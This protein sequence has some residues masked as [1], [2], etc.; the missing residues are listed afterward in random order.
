VLGSWK[1]V[2]KHVL[3]FVEL[4]RMN[5]AAASG[6][7]EDLVHW[8]LRYEK[9]LLYVINGA[10]ELARRFKRCLG[11]A[12]RCIAVLHLRTSG[13]MCWESSKGQ[14]DRKTVKRHQNEA[15]NQETYNEAESCLRSI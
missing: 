11:T 15:C 1:R 2:L 14:K 10:K 5:T 8:V 3:G 6:L 9:G 12:T 7:L 13:R 4:I